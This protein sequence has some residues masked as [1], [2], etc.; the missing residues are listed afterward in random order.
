MKKLENLQTPDHIREYQQ[1]LRADF[2]TSLGE[3][4]GRTALNPE[5][6]GTIEGSDYRIEKLIYESRPNFF[7]TANLYLPKTPAPHPAVLVP[8]G[9]TA[10]GKAGY[11]KVGLILAKHGIAA[12]I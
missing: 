6:V 8:C 2:L 10:N 5:L 1:H 7:V 11:Q 4:P 9:H 12:L 3:F